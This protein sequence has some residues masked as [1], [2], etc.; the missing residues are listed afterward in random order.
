LGLAPSNPATTCRTTGVVERCAGR[1]AVWIG[2][3]AAPSQRPRA[4]GAKLSPE[5]VL[6]AHAIGRVDE[7]H[8]ERLTRR[9]E[10]T[11]DRG[12]DAAAVDGAQCRRRAAVR[13]AAKGAQA[14]DHRV[15]ARLAPGIG[16]E[17]DA[18]GVVS[19][20]HG[21]IAECVR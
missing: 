10:L 12:H 15:V 18:A 20:G 9:H 1:T 19:H 14:E 2:R 5:E 11:R 16:D 21:F 3:D 17:S 4:G 7:H 8:P 6:G 13:D